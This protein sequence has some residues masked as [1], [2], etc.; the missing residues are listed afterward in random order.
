MLRLHENEKVII[1]FH[2]H[3][4]VVANK[5]TFAIALFLPALV[6]LIALPAVEINAGLMVLAY[7]L[8][9][10]YMMIALMI[11]FVIWFDYYLDIWIVTNE[12][13]IDVEQIGMFKREVSEFMLSRV[14]DI[15]VEIPNF[16]ATL[17]HYGNIRVQ[18]AGEQGFSARDIPQPD[19]IKDIILAETRKSNHVRTF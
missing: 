9:I 2:R 17:L 19:K 7:Y 13:I 11:A 14:Q 1:A 15:T 18:T 8:I 4:L 5:M 12:I 16:M 10:A 6:A 3:W